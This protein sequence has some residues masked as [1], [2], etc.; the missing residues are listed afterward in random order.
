MINSRSRTIIFIYL[1]NPTLRMIYPVYSLDHQQISMHN[2]VIDH[3]I[4]QHIDFA[5]PE[6]AVVLV[7][8]DRD[9]HA[10]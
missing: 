9:G 2:H 3:S 6:V 10:P 1:L 8:G 5:A 4:K 7:G